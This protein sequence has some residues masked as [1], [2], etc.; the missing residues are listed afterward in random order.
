MH[1]SH[2]SPSSTRIEIWPGNTCFRLT[3]CCSFSFGYNSCPI[4]T[5][6][7]STVHCPW[8]PLSWTPPPPPNNIPSHL[9]HKHDSPFN[10][11]ATPPSD[12]SLP[13]TSPD[14]LFSVAA[15]YLGRHLCPSSC[16]VTDPTTLH[17][18]IS[19]LNPQPCRPIPCL[20]HTSPTRLLTPTPRTTT[21]ANPP[22]C[23]RT[24]TLRHP[25]SPVPPALLPVAHSPRL[26]PS[27]PSRATSFAHRR[28]RHDG[29][30]LPAELFRAGVLSPGS[31]V[32]KASASRG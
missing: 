7:H 9:T 4:E 5:L 13:W 18:S 12:D 19:P 32:E 22:A 8:I 30:L 20:T 31:W 6:S 26:T 15:S 1:P 28:R 23:L 21:P 17:L 29:L 2:P 16:P 24:A 3:D 25:P 14:D 11:P 10:L 27:R